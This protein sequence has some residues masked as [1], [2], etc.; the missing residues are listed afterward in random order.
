MAAGKKPV[1]RTPICDPSYLRRIDP[2]W[3]PGPVP[4]RFWED[5]S[6][7]RDYLLWLGHKLR[8]RYLEDWYKL[9]SKHLRGKYAGGLK[10]KYWR[11]SPIEAVK[12]CFPEYDWKEWFFIKVPEEFWHSRANRRKY[13]HWLGDRLGY[14][15]LDDWYGVTQKDFLHNRGMT[16]LSM[17]C[18]APWL[19]I[20]DLFPR[21][22]WHEWKFTHVAKGFWDVAENRRR[23]LRWLGQQLGFR[24]PCDW[25]RISYDDI[26]NHH[27]STLLMRYS[28]SL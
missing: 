4:S 11:S 6:H 28:F 10:T 2:V 19:A 3:V 9:N 25:Y 23:Y 24:R 26:V 13:I 1:G 21:R 15:R 20:K 5:P 8:F 7:R 27:G 12:E 22:D 16:L 17:Y 18:N 14:Q